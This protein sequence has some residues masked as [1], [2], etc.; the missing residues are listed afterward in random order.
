MGNSTKYRCASAFD[1]T[2][3]ICAL[4]VDVTENQFKFWDA[5]LALQKSSQRP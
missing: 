3:T 2:L 1:G 4:I 5:E